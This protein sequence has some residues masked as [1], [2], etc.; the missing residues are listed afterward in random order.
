[1]SATNYFKE[2]PYTYRLKKP[3]VLD[4]VLYIY[5]LT[6]FDETSG[7]I[8]TCCNV[9][10]DDIKNPNISMPLIP[11]YSARKLILAILESA[12]GKPCPR[13]PGI[14]LGV[15]PGGWEVIPR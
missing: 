6:N 1:M 3:L 11:I 8:N 14:T 9:L 7:D 12:R 2:Q 13:S 5:T 15:D 4:E 10:F